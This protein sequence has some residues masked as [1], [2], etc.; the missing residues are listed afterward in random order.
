MA[1]RVLF[2]N[3]LNTSELS[4]TIWWQTGCYA[5][6]C[7]FYDDVEL[8][9]LG[10]WVDILGTNC[11]RCVC[12]VQCCFTSTET[13]RLIRTGSSGRPPRLSH[14]SWTLHILF[15]LYVV[16]GVIDVYC[17]GTQGTTQGT[18]Q[19]RLAGR[20]LATNSQE[21]MAL[22][23]VKATFPCTRLLIF[24]HWFLTEDSLEMPF[25]KF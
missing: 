17:S 5:G 19:R 16:H 24:D 12:M 13:I 7:I 4:Q 20:S 21:V 14:S 23:E 22:G 25:P 10:C 9:V 1:D 3:F 18:T 15:S 6:T 8:N 2:K 11:D